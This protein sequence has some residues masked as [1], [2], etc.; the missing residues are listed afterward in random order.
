MQQRYHT[1]IIGGG[2]SGTALAIHLIRR[3]MQPLSVTLVETRERLGRGIAYST[4]LDEHVLNTPPGAMS[5]FSDAPERFSSWLEKCGIQAADP[6][7]VPRS[8]Y[9]DY[10]ED[11]LIEAVNAGGESRVAFRAHTQR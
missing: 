10:L 11:S 9:G 5:L 3:S 6:E 2:F 8:V 4:N 1:V 7:F